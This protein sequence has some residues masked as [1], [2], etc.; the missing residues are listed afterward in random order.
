MRRTITQ[1]GS[2]SE[3]GL[4]Q[5]TPSVVARHPKYDYVLGTEL[6]HSN[7]RENGSMKELNPEALLQ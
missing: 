2:D 4:S 6:K 7:E 5:F 1:Y 3:A